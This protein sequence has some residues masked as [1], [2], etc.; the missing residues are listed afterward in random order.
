MRTSLAQRDS[1][2]SW[3]VAIAVGLPLARI[4]VECAVAGDRDFRVVASVGLAEEL[5]P[6]GCPADLT[7]VEVAPHGPVPAPV[8][9][10]A[11]VCHSRVVVL[12]HAGDPRV[13]ELSGVGAVVGHDTEARD[14]VRALR[15]TAGDRLP[16]RELL[17][18]REVETVRH[19]GQG[20]THRQIARRMG[21]TEAT[22]STYVKR[23]RGKLNV[24]NKAEL[25]LRA[26]AFGYLTER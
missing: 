4:G 12:A 1:E 2:S 25:V 17:S 19:I 20:L 11:L 24:T 18:R 9:F 7:V 14:L 8:V 10:G 26:M 21:L 6:V 23:I 15:V 5:D 13:R 16:R 22:V 3:T